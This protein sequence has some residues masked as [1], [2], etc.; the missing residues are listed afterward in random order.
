[1]RPSYILKTT[2]N[3]E[4]ELAL[5]SVVKRSHLS[6]GIT[7]TFNVITSLRKKSLRSKPDILNSSE[8]N[9]YSGKLR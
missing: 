5:L 4:L 8:Y 7:I 6:K 2:Q 3:I 1:M 9:D